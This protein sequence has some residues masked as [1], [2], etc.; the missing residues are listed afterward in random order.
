MVTVARMIAGALVGGVLLLALL[1]GLYD[2][3]IGFTALTAPSALLGLFAPVLGYRLH[4]LQRQRVP[5][6]ADAVER[7]ARYLRAVIMPLAISGGVALLG[8]VSFA[9]GGGAFSLVGV[10]THVLLTGALWPS[11]ERMTH[12]HDS[13]A[14][15][16]DPSST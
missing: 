12:F 3:S 7:P 14:G 2:P 13:A 10:L 9:L 6:G 16:T 1:V 15:P 5:A 4:A 11:A 8:V